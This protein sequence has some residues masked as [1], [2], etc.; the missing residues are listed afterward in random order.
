MVSNKSLDEVNL[1]AA[2]LHDVQTS[3]GVVFDKRALRNTLKKVSDRTR[4]EGL[5]FLTKTLPRLGKALDKALSGIHNLNAASIG[6]DSLPDSELPRFLGE[7]F[8]LVFHPDGGTS[9]PVCR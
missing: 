3:H 2:L 4:L 9:N 7:F 8:R 6:F 5:S 1:I